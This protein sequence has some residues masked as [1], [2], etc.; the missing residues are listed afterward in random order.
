MQFV[1]TGWDAICSDRMGWIGTG[2][3]LRRK[4]NEMGGGMHGKEGEFG[5]QWGNSVEGK[6]MTILIRK[7][8]EGESGK[9]R[10]GER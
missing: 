6:R 10:V 4:D 7:G 1:V 5:D 8:I 2:I 9:E 3:R